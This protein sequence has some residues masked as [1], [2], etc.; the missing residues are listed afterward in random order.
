MALPA[1]RLPTL[2]AL[3][4]RIA[5]RFR[6]TSPEGGVPPSPGPA[7]AC[8]WPAID[9][10][11]LLR[12]GDTVTVHAPP[13]AGGLS[14]ASAWAR[15]AVVEKEPVLVVDAQD[16]SL[17]HPWVTPAGAK[18]PLWVVAPPRPAGAWPALD[19]ALR[20][21]A[22]GL[23]VLLDPPPPPPGAGP[24]ITHLVRTRQ[25]RLVICGGLR[26]PGWSSGIH[27]HLRPTRIHW[28]TAPTG[29]APA[30]RTLEV[31]V[32]TGMHDGAREGAWDEQR[33]MRDDDVCTDRLRPAPR[34]PDRRPS[35]G[36]GRARYQS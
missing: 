27:L 32:P 26:G 12:A 4:T 9:G 35:H 20:S 31:H 21:G 34:A 11:Y 17:P 30:A 16:A 14:L 33:M 6:G 18:A 15:A 19:I 22:F 10:R 36:R 7:L 13:G 24:R 8:G 1:E 5:A 25:A 28:T 3:R 23:L 2:E 29:A